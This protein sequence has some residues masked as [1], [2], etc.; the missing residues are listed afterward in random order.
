MSSLFDLD[1]WREVM[2]TLAKNKSRSIITAFGVFWGILIFVLLKGA[3]DGV[4]RRV[5]SLFSDQA[6]NLSMI[7]PD[8][9]TEPYKGFQRGRYPDFRYADLVAL[10]ETYPQ[11][12]YATPLVFANW[13]ENVVS[14]ADETY[15]A[16]SFLGVHNNMSILNPPLI[17]SGRFINELD[18][19]EKRKV[20]MLGETVC[21]S[22]FSSDSEPVGSIVWIG[23]TSYRV[24]GIVSD[25]SDVTMLFDYP[26]GVFIPYTTMQNVYGRDDK[27]SYAAVSLPKDGSVRQD[28]VVS[29]LKQRF[30]VAP[31]DRGGI[32][33][34]STKEIFDLFNSLFWGINFLTYLVGLGTLLC[35]MIGVSNIM[36]VTVRER[37]NEI[38]IKRALGASPHQ[39][40]IQIMCESLTL[41]LL[42]GVIG[43]VVGVGVLGIVNFILDNMQNA[44][45]SDIQL[46]L[47]S[48]IKA[49]VII[50]AMG[51]LSGLLPSYR[52]LKIKPVEALAEE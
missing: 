7:M 24:I 32:T 11:I 29:F 3:G 21:N 6:T 25:K 13:G 15:Q 35:G 41:A 18:V 1:F 10:Q 45:L 31:T 19:R 43:I 26:T 33:A 47:G 23:S 44:P 36:L 17:I 30:N 42:A 22:L 37:T 12:E 9:T 49:L 40:I 27:I 4:E 20:C 46:Q 52:A 14:Y 8:R 48:A 38:G 28:D 34:F 51:M 39:I 2:H 16:D 50:T 5:L